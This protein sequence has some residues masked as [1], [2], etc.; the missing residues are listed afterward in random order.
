MIFLYICGNFVYVYWFFY[1]ELVVVFLLIGNK[2][3]FNYDKV[4]IV[5]IYYEIWI[6]EFIL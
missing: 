4:L 5:Y 1:F 2:K 3:F 6:F